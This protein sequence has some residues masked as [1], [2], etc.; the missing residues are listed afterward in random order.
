M[1]LYPHRIRRTMSLRGTTDKTSV[2]LDYCSAL[3]LAWAGRW[4]TH[5]TG[6]TRPAASAVIRRALAVYATHL[7]EPNTN[8]AHEAQEVRRAS[9]GGN[10][11]PERQ[12]EADERFA[13]IPEAGPVPP[14][15]DIVSGPGW[16]ERLA[17]FDARVDAAVASM[18]RRW[19]GKAQESTK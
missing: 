19:A 3:A 8:P 12:H 7:Q 16:R 13:A 14:L 15:Q 9:D 10:P 18:G 17:A 11:S 6:G 5:A 4:I 2:Q 1:P